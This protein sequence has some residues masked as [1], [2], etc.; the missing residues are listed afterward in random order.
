M[1]TVGFV[2]FFRTQLD[3]V[4]IS[5]SCNAVCHCEQKFD[6]VCGRDNIMY[7]SAC[8]AGCRELNE[9]DDTVRAT[10]CDTCLIKVICIFPILKGRYEMRV[11]Y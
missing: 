6:P 3:S 2:L 11:I 4:D 9:D 1:T 5:S 10:Q 8:H 7:Y